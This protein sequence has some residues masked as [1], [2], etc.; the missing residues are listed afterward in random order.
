[1]NHKTPNDQ[2]NFAEAPLNRREFNQKLAIMAG[3][4][5]AAQLLWKARDLRADIIAE[6]DPRLAAENVT[7]PG[8]TGD[9]RAYLAKPA[10]EQKLPAV[11]VIHEN[12]GLQPH[13]RDVARRM[14]LEGFLA[15]APDALS[16]L[17][18][19]P[20]NEDDARTKIGELDRAATVK[21]FVAAVQYLKTNPLTTGKVGCTGFCW[22]GAMTNQVAVH[23]PD[24]LAAVPYYGGQPAIEDV[25]KIKASLLLHY[26]GD[27]ERIN[28]GIPA[29]EAALIAAKI[30]YKIFIYDGAKHAFNNDANPAR[31]HKEA[32]EL[33][34]QRTVAFFKEKLLT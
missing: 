19:T 30:E 26:A 34:W 11:I 32:A 27:D 10:G 25:P 12:R 21:N 31:Y 18:G 2:I 33:A 17:G 24:L 20:E 6:D 4:A 28:A 23:A 29:F 9:I 3:S 15:L 14:A 7:Y 8:E 1:M 16:P 13:I 22:G 5:A